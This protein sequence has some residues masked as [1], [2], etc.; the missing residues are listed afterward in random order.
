MY[1]V[2]VKA[3]VGFYYATYKFYSDKSRDEIIDYLWDVAKENGWLI[4][5]IEVEEVP[6]FEALKVRFSALV[7]KIKSAFGGKSDV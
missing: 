7:S 2:I 5:N 6:F 4:K 3:D 1:K